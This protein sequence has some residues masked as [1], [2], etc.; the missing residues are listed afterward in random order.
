MSDEITLTIDGKTVTVPRGATIFEAARKLGIEIPHLCYKPELGLPPTSSCRLCV[1]E[2]EGAKSLVASC[3]HPVSPGMVV[4]TDTE[5]LRNVRRMVIDLLLSNHPH[6]CLTCEKSGE[7]DLQKYAYALGVRQPEFAGEPVM[8]QPIEDGPAIIYDP[9]KCILCGRCVE[10]CHQVQVTG[11]IDYQGR[12]FNTR[13]TLPPGLPRDRSGCAECGNCVDV[14][15]TG[16]LSYAGAQGLG[17]AWEMKRVPTICPYCGC[18]C[19]VV[20]NIRDNRVVKITGAPGVGVNKGLLCVK[21]RFGMDWVGH[22]DRLTRPMLRRN[23]RLEPVSWEEAL[24]YA[25]RRLDEIRRESGPDAIGGLASAKCTNEENYVFQKF[26]RAV[27]GTN[28]VDHCARLCHASTVAGLA[29][30]FGSGAMTNSIEDFDVTD[31]I[32]VIGSNTTECHPVIGAAIKRA[33]TQRKVP[34]IVADPRSIELV[35][36]A[37]V[38]LRQKGG[39]D[40]ALINAMIHV[41][42]EEGLEDAEFIA[43]RTEGFE[44]LKKA[45]APYTPEMGEKITGVPAA[46][47]V[48]AARIYANAKA[49][50]IVYSMGIT[51]HSHGTDNVLALANLAMVTGNVGKP[52][53][54]V[55]PLRGQNNVQGACDMGALPNLLPGYQSV[56]D[57]AL[58]AKFEKAWGVTIPSRPGLTVVEMM[59]AA[60][61]GR[62]RA[63]YIMGENPMLS[64]PDIAHV[65]EGLRRLDL[66]IVQDIFMSETAQIAHVVL[67]AVGFAEKDGTFTNTERRVQRVRK[68][69]EPPGEA[70]PDWVITCDLAR[71]LGREMSYHNEAAIQDEIASLTPIYG[72]ITYDRLERGALQW[73]CPDRNHPGTPY[74]HKEKFTRGLGK[75]HAVEFVPSKELP[76]ADYPFLL[77]TGRI[78][79]HFHT[80]TMSRRSSVLDRLVSVGAIEIH[81]T[82]AN[83]LGVRDGERVRVKSRRGQIEIAARVTDRVAPGTV[84]LAFHYREAPANRLT[85][86]ALDPVAK[87]P[88]FK[89]C[90]VRIE[91]AR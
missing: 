38:H 52:G 42:I 73:P 35:E 23:G 6:D 67:P 70:R 15:P 28:N 16:A 56:T 27:I 45:V 80:G 31:C 81:P 21:G 53:A 18:G 79:Q 13:V 12:G 32:F 25:A 71:R 20:L 69:I 19:T 39:T 33:A 68:G 62:L 48:K 88:E 63:L 40:V 34:L 7:C 44:E 2:V 50:S 47:I 37:E 85:I 54:G 66:L 55:N 4:R 86:A 90:A 77:S 43:R 22:G 64:D 46:D 36:F 58:R 74:L 82:D 65:E 29:K 10:I 84:F 59:N 8:V 5:R 11:A 78:L 9:S 89:V 41:I 24:D 57:D 49:A 30:A 76:D 91:P 51:Q 26:M 72:G 83:R 17:R 3:S 14:C 1:V 61:E 75:F 60:A 87:I